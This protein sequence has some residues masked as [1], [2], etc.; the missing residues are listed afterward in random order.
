[1]NELALFAGAGGGLLGGR[2]LGWRAVCYVEKNPY[3]IEVLKARIRD[4]YLDDAPI[5]DDVRTFNG[6]PWAGLVDVVTAGFPCQPFS[7]AGKQL[8]EHDER[9]LWP[10]TLRIIR[11]VEPEWCLLENV[12][13]LLSNRYIRRIFA[14]LAKGG[15]DYR[16]DCIPASAVGAPHQR[17]RLWIVAHAQRPG[18]Q[19]AV[20]Q[21]DQDIRNAPRNR[22]PDHAV[23]S[24]DAMAHAASTRGGELSVRPGRPRESASDVDRD[25]HDVSNADDERQPVEVQHNTRLN[26]QAAQPGSDG[27]VQAVANAHGRGL[28]ESQDQR[29]GQKDL[30]SRPNIGRRDGITWWD[31]EPKLGRVAHGVAHRVDRLEAIGNGQVPAVARAAWL[32]LSQF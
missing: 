12:S 7:G 32:L 5:W 15:Y 23:G 2:L 4:G 24:S 9:N 21:S 25:G 29:E 10:D 17:D 27:K 3:C 16:W 31:V 14:D 19:G 8:G 6:R 30:P 13:R 18:R 28:Q 26:E 22:P 1:M 11:E 20:Q